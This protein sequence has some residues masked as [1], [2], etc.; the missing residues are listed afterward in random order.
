M[1]QDVVQT[2]LE[3]HQLGT[4]ITVLGRLFHAHHPLMKNLFLTPI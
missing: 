1:C 2:L 4:M 3:L